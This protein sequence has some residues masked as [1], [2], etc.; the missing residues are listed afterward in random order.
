MTLK[1]RALPFQG[2]AGEFARHCADGLH[3]SSL[4]GEV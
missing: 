3:F 2:S 1:T 4:T